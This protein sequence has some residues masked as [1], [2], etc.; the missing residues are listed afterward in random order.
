M[1]EGSAGITVPVIKTAAYPLGEG[2]AQT[3][4]ESRSKTPIFLP[5]HA[6]VSATRVCNHGQ[7]DR[8]THLFLSESVRQLYLNTPA[9]LA[10]AERRDGCSSGRRS[11]SPVQPFTS[12]GPVGLIRGGPFVPATLLV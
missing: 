8:K 5:R 9:S 6:S 2:E 7:S 12:C 4:V 1:V 11:R 3:I 10:C